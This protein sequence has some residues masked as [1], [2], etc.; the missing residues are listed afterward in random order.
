MCSYS[1]FDCS[2]PC[3]RGYVSRQHAPGTVFCNEDTVHSLGLERRA[4]VE[5]DVFLCTVFIFTVITYSV[6]YILKKKN[7]K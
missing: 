5:E 2:F 1:R 3:R 6:I 4:L 7:N